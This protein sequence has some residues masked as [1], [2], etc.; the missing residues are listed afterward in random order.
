MHW[1]EPSVL[2]S[3]LFAAWVSKGALVEGHLLVLPK[4][5][6]LNLRGMGPVA[7]SKLPAFLASVVT[8]VEASYGPVC[9]FEHG[10]T[11][12]GSSAGCSI[13]HAHMHVLP[14]AGSLIEAAQAN[15]RH[16]EWRPVASFD[17]VLNEPPTDPYLFVRNGDGEM[18]LATHPDIPSQALR[19]TIAAG[20]GREEEWDWK[21]HPRPATVQKTV[22]RLVGTAA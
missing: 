1:R 9:M 6:A 5:H 11:R 8:R 15:Y 20:L 18:A 16:F 4:T 14:W 19:R 3:D 13:D 22:R 2:E 12:Y 17:E 21:R 10:P 7:R